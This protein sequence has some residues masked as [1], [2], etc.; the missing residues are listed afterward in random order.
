MCKNKKFDEVA[1]ETEDITSMHECT[2][3][4][5]RGVGDE[6]YENLM[7]IQHFSAKSIEDE[8]ND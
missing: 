5:P 4:V 6:E 8:K 1:A 2:G 3:L 7:K